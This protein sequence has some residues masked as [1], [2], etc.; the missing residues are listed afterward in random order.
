MKSVITAENISK[1]FGKIEVIKSISAKIYENEIVAIIGPNG[2]GKTTTIE[3]LLGILPPT[4]GTINIH[5]DYENSIGAQLQDT[6]IFPEL[7]VDENLVIFLSFHGIKQTKAQR[8]DTLKRFNLEEHVHRI[9]TK[10]S[11]G[12]Q[13]KLAIALATA[14]DP[15]LIILDEPSSALDPK[16]KHEII[17]LIKY[18]SKKGKTVVFTSHDM[19]EVESLADKVIFIKDGR[20]KAH[21][22]VA[23]LLSEY[24]LRSLEELYLNIVNDEVK[25]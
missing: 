5:S 21:D 13:K 1:S 18:L 20:V 7:T 16:A 11:G 12:Q 15:K 6:P 2:S 3:L 10:L 4:K 23:K 22:Y 25:L 9:A 8:S 19:S 24:H 14:H 17:S